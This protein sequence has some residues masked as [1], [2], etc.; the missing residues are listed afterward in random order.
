MKRDEFVLI[1]LSV[2]FAVIIASL[3]WLT[4]YG[5]GSY[6]VAIFLCDDL[7]LASTI[8]PSNRLVGLIYLLLSAYSFIFRVVASSLSRI[9]ESRV[10]AGGE[11]R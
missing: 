1:S 10:C 4:I 9:N 6:G 11:L 7:H 5:F 8:S 3:R 2:L